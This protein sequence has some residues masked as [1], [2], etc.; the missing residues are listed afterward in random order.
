MNL[1]LFPT[2]FSY[3]L[4]HGITV[5]VEAKDYYGNHLK[6]HV[7][8]NGKIVDTSKEYYNNKTVGEKQKEIYI[9]LYER[10]LKKQQ[11]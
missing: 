11:K 8:R 9:T 2:A 1:D 7:K 3:C 5:E 4:Q 6:I 10:A